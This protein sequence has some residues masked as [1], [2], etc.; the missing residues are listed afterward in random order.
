[1]PHFFRRRR[2]FSLDD[3]DAACFWAH[4]AGGRSNVAVAIF[5]LLVR[6][7]LIAMPIHASET[8]GV[9][10][11]RHGCC[12]MDHSELAVSGV[13]ALAYHLDHRIKVFTRSATSA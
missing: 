9:G 13:R 10:L 5:D 6:A 8:A 4:F 2:G 11:A 7:A 12:E 1:M 3:G